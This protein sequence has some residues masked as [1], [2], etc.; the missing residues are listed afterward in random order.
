MRRAANAGR[1]GAGW[2]PDPTA[3]PASTDRQAGWYADPEAQDADDPR[4][5]RYFDGTG[6]TAQ[7]QG[8]GLPTSTPVPTGRRLAL[9]GSTA[10]AAFGTLAIWACVLFQATEAANASSAAVVVTHET[11]VPQ[12]TPIA[13]RPVDTDAVPPTPA[14]GSLTCEDLYADVIDAAREQREGLSTI[15]IVTLRDTV[16]LEDHYAD[17]VAGTLV[18]APGQT[19]AVVLS[20]RGVATA[21]DGDD[22]PIEYQGVVDA[23]RTWSVSVKDAAGL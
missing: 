20:C 9:V 13:A 8:A 14:S 2:Y 22:Y 16:V 15:S 6:W 3:T 21:T 11:S 1:Q 23:D 7:V 10:A 19:E 5:L 17:L 4:R 12:S 18:I